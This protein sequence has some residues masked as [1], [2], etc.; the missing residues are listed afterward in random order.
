MTNTPPPALMPLGRA[1]LHMH[2]SYSDGL[3]TIENI[4][5]FVSR[6]RELDVIAITDHNT[7]EGALRARDLIARKPDAEFEVI[8]GEEVSTHEGHLLTLF[9]E[10]RIPPGLS[11]ERSIE[12]AHEQGGLAIIAHPFNRVFR[13]SIQREVVERLKHAPLEAQPDGIETLNGSFAGIGSSRLAMARN[14]QRYGWPETGSSDAHTVTAIGCAFTWFAG[15]SASDLRASILDAA[16]MPGGHFWQ[17]QDYWRL[18]SY[19][20]L[21]GRP[22]RPTHTERLRRIGQSE[23]L[24]LLRQFGQFARHP[25]RDR[26]SQRKAAS[27]ALPERIIEQETQRISDRNGASTF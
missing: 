24:A 10:K 22:G 15:T 16:T 5:A 9:I 23:R 4:L 12:L 27:I 8:V 26:L 21:N 2:S 18:A 7:I 11:V 17:G 20:A 6:Q 1:D 13:H 3:G 14:R 25:L 19:W